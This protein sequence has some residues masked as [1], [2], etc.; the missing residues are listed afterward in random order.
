MNVFTHEKHHRD[1][2]TDSRTFPIK[3]PNN[4]II[5][6]LIINSIRNK[7]ELLSFLIGDKVDILLISETKID[8]TFDGT[9]VLM[10]GYS[11]VYRLN[12][13]DKG[14]GIVLFVK[15]NLIIFPVSGFCF[16]EK[17]DILHRIK[18]QE[19]K[20]VDILLLEFS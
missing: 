8:D 15:G 6:H 19:T 4:I 9:E 3:Y 17:S 20:I 5:G 10:G 18:P 13:N 1:T 14:G 11:N 12:R 7:F 16:S 2:I